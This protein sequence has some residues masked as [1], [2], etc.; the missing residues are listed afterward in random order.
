MDGEEGD[1]VN[2]KECKGQEEG[3]EILR[4]YLEETAR[5]VLAQAREEGGEEERCGKRWRSDGG[6]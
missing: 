5:R 3:P 1:E 2:D 6:K 4:A